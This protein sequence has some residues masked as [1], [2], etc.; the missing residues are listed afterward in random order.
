MET[1]KKQG[2]ELFHSMGSPVKVRTQVRKVGR[3]D[4]LVEDPY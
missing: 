4:I 3:A 2:F 1:K